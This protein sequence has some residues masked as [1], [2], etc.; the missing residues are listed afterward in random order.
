MVGNLVLKHLPALVLA[1][2]VLFV[3]KAWGERATPE[4][5]TRIDTVAPAEY[6]R[7]VEGLRIQN[8][9]LRARLEGVES[10]APEVIVRTDT[11][12]LPPDTVLRF[13]SVDSDANL[14]VEIL[15]ARDSLYAPELHTRIDVSRCDDGWQIQSGQVVCD[16]A[17]LGHLYVGPW[18]SRTPSV[19]IWWV[20][21]FRSPW[22][23][24]V[25]FSGS[26]DFGL[27][28]G[29]RIW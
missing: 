11:L 10:R 24:S 3:G 6:E 28:R 26:W 12:V 7:T 23:A 4:V 1:L 9:G 18:L 14:T 29:V 17:Q 22:E 5:V 21:S 16:E 27:R 2:L 25:S 8:E 15:T 19:A 20:P 13:V